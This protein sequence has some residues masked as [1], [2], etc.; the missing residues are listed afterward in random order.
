MIRLLMVTGQRREEVA[1]LDWKELDRSAAEWVIPAARSKNG[2]AHTVPLSQLALDQLDALAG[3]GEWPKKGLVFTTTG[4]TP[5][6]GHS[7]AKERIDRLMI[8]LLD[9]ADLEPWRIHDLR[10]TT[11]TGLQ[12]LGVRFEVTEAVLNHVSGSRSGV[13]GVYQRH[14]WKDEKRDAL[15]AWAAHVERILSGTEETNVVQLAQ[16]A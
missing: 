9:G 7:R 4:K 12:R 6:S 11:A 10:R 1:G 3:D 14:S 15:K 8:E 2:K 13:A 5:A 16:R